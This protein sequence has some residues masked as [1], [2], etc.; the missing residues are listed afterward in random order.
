[1]AVSLCRSDCRG[2]QREAAS[3]AS[4]SPSFAEQLRWRNVNLVGDR[5]GDRD[6]SHSARR[7]V[8]L[9]ARDR[10]CAPRYFPLGLLIQ[11][12]KDERIDDAL[13]RFLP[14]QQTNFD[15]IFKPQR[16]PE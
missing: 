6:A 8:A 10:Q 14:Y 16:V 9:H 4:R 5:L 3:G 1:M 7:L 2:L 12:A 15:R 11:L 13:L